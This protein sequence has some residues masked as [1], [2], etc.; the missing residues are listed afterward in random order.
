MKAE[1]C[2]LSKLIIR[3]AQATN[4]KGQYYYFRAYIMC[5]TINDVSG[6]FS[7]LILV[8]GKLSRIMLEVIT[9]KSSGYKIG[10][11][12]DWVILNL[13]TELF[14]CI[15]TRETIHLYPHEY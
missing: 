15:I 1:F 7:K 5:I 13:M 10:R 4:D 14:A 2:E 11:F 12:S 9:S 8:V 3:P 6:V